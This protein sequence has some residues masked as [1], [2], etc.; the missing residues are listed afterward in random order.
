[1]HGLSNQQNDPNVICFNTSIICDCYIRKYFTPWVIQ[2]F[3][4]QLGEL[5]DPEK[6]DLVNLDMQIDPAQLPGILP[7]HIKCNHM[8]LHNHLIFIYSAT[9]T[10]YNYVYVYKV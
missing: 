7:F 3:Q 8:H 2:I 10:V 1:M 9:H 6:S 5:C 4:A